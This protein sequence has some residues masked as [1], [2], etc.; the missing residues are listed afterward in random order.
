MITGI[1]PGNDGNGLVL[2]LIK[3]NLFGLGTFLIDP[4]NRACWRRSGAGG[5]APADRVPGVD[6]HPMNL[7]FD[8][9]TSPAD[10]VFGPNYGEATITQHATLPVHPNVPTWGAC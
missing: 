3:Q 4:V 2:S 8:A 10:A 1:E 9:A 5:G 6:P 7:R